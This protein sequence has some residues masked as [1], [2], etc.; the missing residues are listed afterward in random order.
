MPPG[1]TTRN[2]VLIVAAVALLSQLPT[3]VASI[4]N[5]TT[6]ALFACAAGLALLGAGYLMTPPKKRNGKP[7]STTSS[8]PPPSK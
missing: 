1:S 5:P 3:T 8:N 6:R 7:S 4:P 2:G